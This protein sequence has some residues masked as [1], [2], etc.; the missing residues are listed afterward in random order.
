MLKWKR[1]A[2]ASLIVSTTAMPAV[3]ASGHAS[4]AGSWQSSDGSAQVRVTMCGDGT[5]LC[6]R[7]TGLSGPA[8][9]PDNLRM[10][11]DYVVAGAQ[12]TDSN[13]WLGTVHFGGQTA[14]GHIAMRGG[15]DILVSGCQL[16]MC[17]TM[18]FHRVSA[19]ASRQTAKAALTPATSTTAVASELP[20]MPP[21][22]VSLT[23]SE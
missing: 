11:N 3:A 22:T 20:Q 21:R 12:L 8:R 5:Q 23:L 7:L 1:L 18:E 16:G 2:A 13:D 6:A 9:T 4:P 14:E 19:V 15:N 17:K 10:L